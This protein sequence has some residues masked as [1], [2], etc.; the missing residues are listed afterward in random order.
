[1]KKKNK[2]NKVDFDLST[3]SLSELIKVYENIVEFLQFL[4]DKRIEE[5][6]KGATPNE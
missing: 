2:K 3:H 4:E 5:E 1:M 6:Q